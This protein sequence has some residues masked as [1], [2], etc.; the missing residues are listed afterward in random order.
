MPRTQPESGVLAKIRPAMGAVSQL[1]YWE[2]ASKKGAH[3]LTPPT[4]AVTLF[5]F[6]RHPVH[7]LRTHLSG[8]I[9]IK[10]SWAP[11]LEKQIIKIPQ[12][13]TLMKYPRC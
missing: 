12:G 6:P 8:K 10:W 5:D 4:I 9:P 3:P 11:T 7:S 13:R 1:L 2:P